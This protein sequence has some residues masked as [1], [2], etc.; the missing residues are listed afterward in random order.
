MNEDD[1]T[2]QG[3]LIYEVVAKLKSTADQPR[4]TDPDDEGVRLQQIVEDALR[5]EA[6]R[7]QFEVGEVRYA[8][9]RGSTH[10]D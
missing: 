10:Y 9:A 6:A 2:W 1:R 5:S 8:G 7:G 4:T 3:V